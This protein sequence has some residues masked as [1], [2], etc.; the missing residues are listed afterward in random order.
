MLCPTSCRADFRKEFAAFSKAVNDKEEAF[1]NQVLEEKAKK[2]AEREVQRE[3]QAQDDGCE[4]QAGA[5]PAAAADVAV[6]CQAQPRSGAPQGAHAPVAGRARE[7]AFETWI[8]EDKVGRPRRSGSPPTHT[9]AHA[10]TSTRADRHAHHPRALRGQAARG[11]TRSGSRPRTSGA[12]WRRRRG[13]GG[14]GRWG[15]GSDRL[16]E[17]G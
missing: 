17:A 11:S 10:C 16:E 9:C 13:E 4:A 2:A 7:E 5:R 1:R 15:K 8:P 12:R 14:V 6:L 3:E